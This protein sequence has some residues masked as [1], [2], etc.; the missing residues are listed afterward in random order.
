M[1]TEEAAKTRMKKLEDEGLEGY[2]DRQIVPRCDWRCPVPG[3]GEQCA[4]VPGH[5]GEHQCP[6][7]H[8]A[9]RWKALDRRVLV[10]A[11]QGGHPRE[12]TCYVGAVPGVRHDEE[13]QEVAAHGSVLGYEVAKWLF[14]SFA[15]SYRYVG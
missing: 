11:K 9:V 8:R 10:V 13:W 7:H 6:V 1:E 3:C 14:P 5:A 2:P 15:R 12:W 4:G